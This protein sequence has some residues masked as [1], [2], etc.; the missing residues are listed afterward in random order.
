MIIKYTKESFDHKPNWETE[1]KHLHWKQHQGGFFEYIYLWQTGHIMD[2]GDNELMDFIIVDIDNLPN[3]KR[4][5]LNRSCDEIANALD[6]KSCHVFDSSSRK[7]DKCKVYLELF[8]P[9]STN[10]METFLTEFEIYCD[11][12][13]DKCTKSAYQLNYGIMLDEPKYKLNSSVF[14]ADIP[15]T[16]STKNKKEA[17]LPVN[18]QEKNRLL[19]KKPYTDPRLEWNY[20][21]FM[22][23]DGSWHRDIITIKEGMRQKVLNLLITVVTFNAT[24]YNKLY[25]RVFTYNE[26]YNKICTIISLQFEHAKQFLNENRQSVYR[27]CYNEWTNQMSRDVMELYSELCVKLNRPERFNYKPREYT[28]AYLYKVYKDKLVGLS[29]DEVMDRIGYI[30]EGEEDLIKNIFRYYRADMKLGRSDKGNKHAYTPRQSSNKYK[31]ILD[32][33]LVK[34]GVYYVPKQQMSSG[35]RS[36]CAKRTIKLKTI[37]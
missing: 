7:D 28:A 23:R 19:G 22:H 35:L 13:V 29:L 26:T 24:M 10:D 32:R 20:Y 15:S 14:G 36:Y 4:E 11:L 8:V 18:Q 9:V 12:E 31:I 5:W 17:F 16:R 33:C 27:M 3:G 21:R 2:I 37:H 6:V 1:C 30:A 25:N 34:D